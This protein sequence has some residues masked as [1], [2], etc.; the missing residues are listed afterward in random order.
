MASTPILKAVLIGGKGFEPYEVLYRKIVE[1]EYKYGVKVQIMH[2]FSH[3][4]LNSFKDKLKGNEDVDIISSHTS[5][6]RSYYHLYADLFSIDRDNAR[7]L[8]D[9]LLEPLKLSTIINDQFLIAPRFIDVSLLHYRVSVFNKLGLDLPR[10]WDDFLQVAIRIKERINELPVK[11]AYA[12]AAK[13]H[14]VVGRFMELLHSFGGKIVDKDGSFAFYSQEGIE[15]LQF[16]ADLHLKYKVTHPNTPDFFYDD[17]SSSFK[18]G[19]TAMVFDWPGWDYVYK[20]PSQSLVWR[21]LGLA[22][23][24]YGKGGRFVYGGSHGL[25]VIKW[26][27][28][29][30][31]AGTFVLFLTSNENQYFECKAQGF[32]PARKSVFTKLINDAKK[33]NNVFEISRLDLYRRTIEESYLPVKIARWREFSE[34]IWPL[35]NKVIRGELNAEEGLKIAYDKV[36]YLERYN[37]IE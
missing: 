16:M 1:F 28:N 2:L 32:L 24:P 4:E 18:N 9:D 36:K 17:V 13:G 20:D 14:A 26:S 22:L 30:N 31:L 25:S 15:A 29:T 37:T 8:Y 10:T 33:E 27:R 7:A 12:F 11:Y 5:F 35:L 21:D 19:E 23:Y 6:L 34:I 3:P